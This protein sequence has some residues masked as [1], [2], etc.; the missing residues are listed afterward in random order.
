MST[1]EIKR[2]FIKGITNNYTLNLAI[3]ILE[4]FDKVGIVNNNLLIEKIKCYEKIRNIQQ[5]KADLID[6]LNERIYDKLEDE[7]ISKDEKNR[8]FILGMELAYKTVLN[9]INGGN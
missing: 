8:Q 7:K 4:E 9:K 3:S 1:E 2:E 6:W 5:E